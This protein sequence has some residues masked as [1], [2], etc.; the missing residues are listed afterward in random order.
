M[1]TLTEKYQIKVF[2]N[3]FFTEYCLYQFLQTLVICCESGQHWM[4]SYN[5]A[6]IHMI[7]PIDF[8]SVPP[9]QSI[10]IGIYMDI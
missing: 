4:A 9:I 8:C 5:G 2:F 7:A 10:G 1:Q 6:K 3:Y